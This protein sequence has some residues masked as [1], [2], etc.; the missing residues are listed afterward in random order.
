MST[1]LP[2]SSWSCT[3]GGSS[4]GISDGR[5]F[6]K[7]GS[8]GRL[9]EFS[10]CE[11]G[12]SVWVTVVGTSVV[13]VS[14]TGCGSGLS[15]SSA[16][17]RHRKTGPPQ[18]VLQVPRWP[19]R[20]RPWRHRRCSSSCAFLA[21]PDHSSTAPAR[22]RAAARIAGHSLP[23]RLLIVLAVALLLT[24]ALLI[25]SGRIELT[26]LILRLLLAWEVLLGARGALGRG[27]GRRLYRARGLSGAWHHPP[28]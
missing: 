14:V 10:S 27:W 28:G 17:L 19:R 24:V 6:W 7:S 9:L 20:R 21:D 13:S 16:A 11:S 23:G 4:V 18:P 2:L 26:S 22:T 5:S 12:S 15:A 1:S 8:F 3:S 25:A